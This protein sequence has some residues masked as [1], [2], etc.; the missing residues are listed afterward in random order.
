MLFRHQ[1]RDSA[2]KHMDELYQCPSTLPEESFGG[3][4]R[5]RRSPQN[6]V[7]PDWGER[8]ECLQ[9]GYKYKRI[10]EYRQNIRITVE[11]QQSTRDEGGTA[12]REK[13]TEERA[14]KRNSLAFSALCIMIEKL[15]NI[16]E[17]A[18]QDKGNNSLNSNGAR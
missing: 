5:E 2:G 9:D 1:I 18:T 7:S 12:Q 6:P 17:T 14:E 16:R 11:Y 10:L 4:S 15:P 8:A 13:E 3:H